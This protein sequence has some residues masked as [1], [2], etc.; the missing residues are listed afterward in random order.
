[1]KIQKRRNIKQECDKLWSRLIKLRAGNKSELS[2]KTENL[3][4]HHIFGKPNL[5]LRYELDN[6]ICLTAGEHKFIA[7]HEGRRHKI[8]E[9]ATIRNGKKRMREL[10][11][12]RSG[13]SKTNLY[14][15]K[16]YLQQELKKYE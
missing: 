5:R 9:L 2:G 1:M 4:S 11:M 15:V 12:M 14:Q 16:L 3:H 10:E 13:V 6:G 8:I 7:H